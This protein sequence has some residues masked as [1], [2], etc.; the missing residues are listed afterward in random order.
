ME[1]YPD[2]PFARLE[3]DSGGDGVFYV[4]QSAVARGP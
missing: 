2:V 4:D 3:F 1:Q